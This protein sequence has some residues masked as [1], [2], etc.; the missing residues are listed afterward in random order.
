MT[1]GTNPTVTRMRGIA[2]R[3]GN[4]RGMIGCHIAEA[5]RAWA[6]FALTSGYALVEING[7]RESSGWVLLK[8]DAMA[9]WERHWRSKLAVKET[10]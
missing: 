9:A 4:T 1:L 2:L 5:S 10:A 3:Y 6:M 7:E 8:E